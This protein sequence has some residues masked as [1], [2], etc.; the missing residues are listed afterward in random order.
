MH[1][2]LKDVT[3]LKWLNN[4]FKFINIRKNRLNIDKNA[5]SQ[6]VLLLG[7]VEWHHIIPRCLGG[8]DSQENG[9][10]LSAREHFIAHQ[11]LFKSFKNNSSLFYAITFMSTHSKTG[12]IFE[13]HRKNAAKLQSVRGKLNKGRHFTYKHRRKISE[14]LLGHQHSVTTKQK[15]SLKAKGRIISDTARD[16][17]SR[18]MALRHKN[19]IHPMLGKHHTAETRAKLSASNTGE[20]NPRFGKIVTA[21]TRTKISAS[22][23]GKSNNHWKRSNDEKA[24]TKQKIKNT[25]ANKSVDEKAQTKAKT[26]LTILQRSDAEKIRIHK[27]KSEA[28][29]NIICKIVTCPHCGKTGGNRGMTRWHFENCRL[30]IN[31]QPAV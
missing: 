2:L 11:Y 4:Y 30:N 26:A 21:E 22:L 28:Q 16:N 6:A 20:N 9:V 10:F 18:A 27:I 15:I 19:H 8:D 13:W 12:G 5:R 1:N 23:S 7:Y 24:Q 14:S 25:Y 29:K 17:L 3:S 31:D